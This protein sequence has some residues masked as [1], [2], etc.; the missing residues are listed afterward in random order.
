LSIQGVLCV[1]ED[2]LVTQPGLGLVGNSPIALARGI[3]R[4]HQA[5][6]RNRAVAAERRVLAVSRF[7]AGRTEFDRR[8]S[9]VLAPSATYLNVG[10]L[11]RSA[12]YESDPWVPPK[13]DGSVRIV[14]AMGGSYWRKGV[15][16]AIAAV[17]RLRAIGVDVELRLM[18]V[19]P[20]SIDSRL[21]VQ[22]AKRHGLL[23]ERVI[24]LAELDAEG[25]IGQLLQSDAFVLPSRADNSPNALCESMMLG[26]PCV[27]STAGG[28][29]SLATD[30][31]DA[32]LVAPA[33]SYSLAGALKELLTDRDLALRLSCAARAR[34][35]VRHDR[36]MVTEQVIAAYQRIA[37]ESGDT[38]M[39]R[40]RSRT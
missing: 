30:G 6:S 20:G 24:Q 1:Y 13:R 26:V 17:A 35:L 18:G 14:S 15:D 7:V 23:D 29:P 39:S 28:I 3:S 10:E 32:L 25:V 9:M 16:T 36:A 27:A 38:R 22:S 4:W 37:A 34:A 31:E 8:V 12:F 11:L 5:R 40:S 19:R 2:A 33:D 21:A